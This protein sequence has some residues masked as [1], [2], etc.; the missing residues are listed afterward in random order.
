MTDTPMQMPA[1]TPA[2]DVPATLAYVGPIF[3][4]TMM[5]HGDNPSYVWHAK[6]GAGLFAVSLAVYVVLQIL[7]RVMPV[8]LLAVFGLIVMA[9]NILFAVVVIY[10]LWQT[11]SG[12]QF[13][14]PFVTNLGQKIPLEKWFH[15]KDASAVTPAPVAA[16]TT[17]ASSSA[18]VAEAPSAPTP[19]PAPAPTPTPA[20]E[21]MP[22]P[23]AETP[24]PE[25]VVT[26]APTP[27]AEAP[28][29][30]SAPT[31]PTPPTPTV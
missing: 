7:V 22:T 30:P 4:W 26:P 12:K 13:V 11:W 3:V 1:P 9:Y 28:V 17:P 25:P 24:A 20:P 14:I 10:S 29:A 8:S 15:P 23:V 21:P 2:K 5:K 19:A 6:N 18:P 31:E 16:P 27:V